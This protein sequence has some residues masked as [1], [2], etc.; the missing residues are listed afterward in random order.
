MRKAL[1]L[2]AFAAVV[3]GCGVHPV[4]PEETGS[5]QPAE[6]CTTPEGQPC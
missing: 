6:E 3:A 5:L 4:A 1:L 2:F